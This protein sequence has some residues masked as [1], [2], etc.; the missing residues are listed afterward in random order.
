MGITSQQ[1]TIKPGYKQTE[2]GVI[3]EDW[4]VKPCSVICDLITVGIVVRPTQYYV[5]QGVPAFRSAN[6][7]EDGIDASDLV[8]ISDKSNALLAKSQVRAGDVITVRTGY[9]GTSA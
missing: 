7:R 4:E 8:F 9:P 5:N 2:M 6:I 1:Q 3:P